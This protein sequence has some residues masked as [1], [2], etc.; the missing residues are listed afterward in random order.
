V[1]C[2]F[3]HAESVFEGYGCAF[4]AISLFGYFE[5]FLGQGGAGDD[6]YDCWTKEDAEWGVGAET[7]AG[8]EV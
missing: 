2:F 1:D 3:G 6:V 8:E 4:V 7:C 5:E